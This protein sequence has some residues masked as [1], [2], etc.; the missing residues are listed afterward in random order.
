MN[1]DKATRYHRAQR[2]TFWIALVLGV[3][4][5]IL[6]LPGGGAVALRQWL[7]AATGLAATSPLVAV[8]FALCLLAAF[9]VIDLPMTIYRT[10]LQRRYEAALERPRTTPIDRLK[11][12]A[13]NAAMVGAA[14]F[15]IYLAMALSS[16]WWWVIVASLGVGVRAV[17]GR[18]ANIY[19]PAF[20]KCR[21]LRRSTLRD[22]LEALGARAG[23]HTL[24]IYEWTPD[25]G[26]VQTNARL[27]GAGDRCRILLSKNLLADFSPDEVE[28]IVAHELGHHVHRDIRNGHRLRTVLAFVTGGVAM[29]ALD[30]M[31][32]P[33]GLLA[34][35]DAAGW[36][37]LL[38]AAALVTIVTEPLLKGL[39]RRT[40]FRADRFAVTLTGRSDV[41][42]STLRRLADRRLADMRPS[43]ATIWLFHS[44]PT[45]E[46]RIRAA[47]ASVR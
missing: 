4:A 33:L 9:E 11:S 17:F 23:I 27:I 37:L 39:S 36:P 31:W 40:E 35:N 7:V 38:A 44:H 5:L 28:V 41:F 3:V 15:A 16:R 42:A 21:M 34:P 19:P 45:V 24:D 6:L 26:T 43:L 8:L 47:S 14:T 20:F 18:G 32:R 13:V 2:T 22:R 1:E 25:A 29:V 30:V 12:A 46:Q 10:R